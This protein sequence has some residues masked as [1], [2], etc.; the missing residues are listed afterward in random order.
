MGESLARSN[1]TKQP[2][3]SIASESANRS[4]PLVAGLFNAQGEQPAR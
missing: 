4:E 3:V 2:A 1:A